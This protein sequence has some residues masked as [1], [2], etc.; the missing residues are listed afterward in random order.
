MQ[1]T[2]HRLVDCGIPLIAKVS[3][4]VVGGGLLWVALADLVVCAED[5]SFSLPEASFGLPP[6]V[7]MACLRDRLTPQKLRLL[8]LSSETVGARFAREIGLVDEVVAAEALDSR[9]D[10]WA[11]KLGRPVRRVAAQVKA[12]ATEAG[13]LDERLDAA[14]ARLRESLADPAARAEIE[15]YASAVSLLA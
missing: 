2:L 6:W 15:S 7:V 4:K 13:S 11:K 3:G 14:C 1:R 10:D 9:C 12:F 8:A 5:A